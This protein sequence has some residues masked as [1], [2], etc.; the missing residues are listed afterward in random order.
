MWYKLTIKIGRL[1]ISFDFLS[2]YSSCKRHLF[3][4]RILIIQ[5]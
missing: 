1:S 3:C 2:I 4:I 5:Y